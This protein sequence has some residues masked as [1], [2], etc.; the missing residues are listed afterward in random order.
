MNKPIA[1]LEAGNVPTGERP[2]S[3]KVYQPG[4]IWPD[5]RVPFREVAVLA[6]PYSDHIVITRGNLMGR[7]ISREV[8]RREVSTELPLLRELL[9]SS[10][11]SLSLEV[12]RTLA[13]RNAP[14]AQAV[15][16]EVVADRRGV[17]GTVDRG[18]REEGHG[19]REETV[20]P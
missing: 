6:D 5:I 13:A 2:G 8:E 16:A 17:L 19:Q 9:S 7:E 11:P 10:E 14:D 4:V 20:A 18:A 12:V 1:S 3:K 15:L